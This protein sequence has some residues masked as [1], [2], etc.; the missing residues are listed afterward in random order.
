[1]FLLAEVPLAVVL[2]LG[3]FLWLRRRWYLLCLGLETLGDDSTGIGDLGGGGEVAVLWHFA[4]GLI[5]LEP[6]LFG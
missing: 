4:C 3:F 1:M 5:L 2:P 6:F